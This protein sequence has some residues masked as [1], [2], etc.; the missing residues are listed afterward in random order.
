MG[1]ITFLQGVASSNR[2]H[3]IRGYTGSVGVWVRSEL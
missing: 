3:T 2:A 1:G